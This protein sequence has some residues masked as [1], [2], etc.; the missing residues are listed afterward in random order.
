METDR[1]RRRGLAQVGSAQWDGAQF[2]VALAAAAQSETGVTA[3]PAGASGAKDLWSWSEKKPQPPADE[4]GEQDNPSDAAPAAT[5]SSQVIVVDLIWVACGATVDVRGDRALSQLA[6]HGFAARILGGVPTL[7]DDCRWPG[8]PLYFVGPY[9]ALT[10]G[11]AAALPPG[12]R[13]AAEAVSAALARGAAAAARGERPY[14]AAGGGIPLD[15]LF[16]DDEFAD[17]H[18]PL[19]AVRAHVLITTRLLLPGLAT[20][21]DY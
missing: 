7:D 12:H 10:V 21:A 20:R 16:D 18:A 11:A 2:S 17:P 19:P 8:L 5:P 13:M 4:D 15:V 14:E 3:A 9:A 1:R 6:A